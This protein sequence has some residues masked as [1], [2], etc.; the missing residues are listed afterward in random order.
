MFKN[1]LGLM[2]ILRSKEVIWS[3]SENSGKQKNLEYKLS[4]F[5]ILGWKWWK[6]N[7]KVI[8]RNV[9]HLPKFSIF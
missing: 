3:K 5:N 4:N 2:K 8:I 9:F 6:A 7:I 1:L